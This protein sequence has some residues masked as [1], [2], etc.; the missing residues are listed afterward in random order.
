L[1]QERFADTAKGVA[2]YLLGVL[3]DH[4][5]GGFFSSQD[6]DEDY[7]RLPATKRARSTPPKVVSDIYSGW[8]CEAVST[9][10][11]AGVLLGEG[12]WVDAGKAAWEYSIDHHWNPDLAMVRHRKGEEL[13]LFEDQVSFFGA[14]MSMIELTPADDIEEMLDMGEAIISGVSKAFVHPDGGYGDVMIR[15][16]AVGEL[17]EPRR[18]IVSNSRWARSSA[19][20]GVITFKPERTDAT[21]DILMSFHPKQIQANG[22]FAAPYVLAWWTLERGT[23]LV[24]I[25]GAKDKDMTSVPLWTEA[26]RSMNLGTMVMSARRV[27]PE[28]PGPSKLFAVVCRSTGCSKEIDD[29]RTL[30]SKLREPHAGQV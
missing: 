17:V 27:G 26:K 1:G 6:A 20:F 8:N 28:I 10:I 9:F 4:E 24:E 21:R 13:Y 25:H 12:S 7:Y 14:L 18:S 15:K 30:L 5:T 16:D 19:L 29:P 2:R 3:R 23:Q 11:E 22:L